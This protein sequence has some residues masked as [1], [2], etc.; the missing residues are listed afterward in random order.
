MSD[1]AVKD[2]DLNSLF[3]VLDER[4]LVVSGFGYFIGKKSGRIIIKKKKEVIAQYAMNNLDEIILMSK[5][6]SISTSLINE[7]CKHG[8]KICIWS[9]SYPNVMISSPQ[10]A[11]FAEVKRA[12][13]DALGKPMGLILV[14][15]ILES[16][17]SNQAALIKYFVKNKE[18]G[19]ANHFVEKISEMENMAFRISKIEEEN[20]N[21]ARTTLLN[22]E[23]NAAH[24]YW[25]A[26]ADLLNRDYGFKGRD[27]DG[28]DIINVALNYGYAILYSLMWMGILNAGLEP[29]AG[30]LHTDRPGK[31]SLVLDLSEPFKPRLVDKIILSIINRKK[32]IGL[33][34]S[35]LDDSSRELI[36]SSIIGELNKRE[37]YAGKKLTMRSIIQS[38]IYSVANFLKGH[39]K[40][41]KY[42]FKW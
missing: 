38:N 9:N 5:G 25:G 32:K 20:V 42:S 19:D 29:F 11:A 3:N 10:L 30:F 8:I 34:N 23:A 35:M 14:K 6:V 13:F 31:P 41:I 27:Y 40:Y 7:A 26:F 18:E 2:R 4:T 28:A 22:I 21:Q 36:S 24:I 12:Q 1:V 37:S 17:I 39:G 33:E 16:K 15:D